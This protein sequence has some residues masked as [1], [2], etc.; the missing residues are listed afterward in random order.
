MAEPVLARVKVTPEEISALLSATGV[1]TTTKKSL[2]DFAIECTIRTIDAEIGRLSGNA[3]IAKRA[4]TEKKK[5]Q[6]PERQLAIA[7]A[8]LKRELPAVIDAAERRGDPRS[9]EY[10]ALL[11]A[12]EK[13]PGFTP[14]ASSP[15]H[16]EVF[17]PA[18][19]SWHTAARALAILYKLHINPD[20]GFSSGP[21]VQFIVAALGRIGWAVSPDAARKALDPK[22][23]KPDLWLEWPPNSYANGVLA[24]TVA[25]TRP[26]TPIWTKSDIAICPATRPLS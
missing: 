20:E 23:Q 10:R 7:I 21:G 15:Q 18:K 11:A 17:A 8:T 4:D 14:L 3:R 19:P 5:K 26:L 12:A 2:D 1:S 6:K 16:P 24:R 22:R 9:D 25:G 13:S